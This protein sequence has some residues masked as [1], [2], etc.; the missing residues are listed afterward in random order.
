MKALKIDKKT[1][2]KTEQIKMF[3]SILCILNDIELSSTEINILAYYIQYKISHKTDE[4]IIASG[5]VKDIGLLRNAK[6]R[7]CKKGFLKRDPKEYKTYELN[8]TD[9]NFEDDDIR[10]LIKLDNR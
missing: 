1:K 5:I 10:L 7:L 9:L 6:Y 2:T 4:F 8:G 3:V